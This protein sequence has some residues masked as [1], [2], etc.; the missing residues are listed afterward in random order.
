M[1][2]V[3]TCHISAYGSVALTPS[4]CMTIT[5]PVYTPSLP[6]FGNRLRQPHT[7]RH[8]CTSKAA[9]TDVIGDFSRDRSKLDVI[10][11]A[12]FYRYDVISK[13]FGRGV[14]S[15]AW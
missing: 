4:I 13:E 9:P 3:N 1:F 8:R 10:H 6:F 7:R 11:L 2:G 15:K 14:K 5:P 12:S